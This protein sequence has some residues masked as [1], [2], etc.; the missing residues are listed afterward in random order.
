MYQP[1]IL[2]ILYFFWCFVF[3]CVCVCVWR[4]R[5][6]EDDGT[7]LF[8]VSRGV[9]AAPFEHQLAGGAHSHE[10]LVRAGHGRDADL[11]VDVEDGRGAA[12]LGEGLDAHAREHVVVVLVRGHDALLKHY[13]LAVVA[14]EGV[15][16]AASARLAGREGGVA[17]EA[18]LDDGE[19]RRVV[20]LF[21]FFFLFFLK[22]RIKRRG[23]RKGWV[24]PFFLFL[25]Q[26]RRRKVGRSLVSLGELQVDADAAVLAGVGGQVAGADAGNVR[27]EG[28]VEDGACG[29][30][31]HVGGAGGA[32][33][34]DGGDADDLDVRGGRGSG[35]GEGRGGG[36]GADEESSREELHFG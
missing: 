4:E 9:A 19:S 18:S 23:G 3:L 35:D 21:F 6:D 20:S 25:Y 29:V 7:F 31:R 24:S 22:T 27:V 33:R 15:A 14:S 12:A 28:H 10:A 36:G 13:L 2:F 34:A 16:R 11:G 8:L 32:T 26:C 30:E 5:K 1:N 17:L